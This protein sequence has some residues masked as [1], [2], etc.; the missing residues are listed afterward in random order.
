MLAAVKHSINDKI[1]C[2]FLPFKCTFMQMRPHRHIQCMHLALTVQSCPV[3]GKKTHTSPAHRKKWCGA[4]QEEI[5]ISTAVLLALVNE[6]THTHRV[7]MALGMNEWMQ[8]SKLTRREV[9]SRGRQSI[10]RLSFTCF[11]DMLQ[12]SIAAAA[13]AA[14]CSLT[15]LIIDLILS[16]RRYIFKLLL[17]CYRGAHSL[18]RSLTLQ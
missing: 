13:A 7:R 11:S 4:P 1:R 6:H 12:R 10:D 5:C 9:L 2:W 16:R 15:L 17:S 3:L 14:Y 8:W 18:T